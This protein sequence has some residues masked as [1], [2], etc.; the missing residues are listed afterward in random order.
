MA[1]IITIRATGKSVNIAASLP[2]VDRL[3]DKAIRRY[4]PCEKLPLLDG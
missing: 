1:A 2:H 4:L 3:S